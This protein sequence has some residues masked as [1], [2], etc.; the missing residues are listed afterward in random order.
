[1]LLGHLPGIELPHDFFPQPG[2]LFWTPAD[3][4]WVGGL[5]D[6]LM[7]A[8]H[9]GVPVL[10]HR[11]RKFEP[12]AAMALMGRHAVRNVFLPP[13]ALKMMRQVGVRGDG[14]ALRTL[15]S[16][17]ETLGAELLDWGR[18]VF[19]VTI[20]EFYGQT[21]CNLVVCNSATLFEVRPGSMGR[22]I[23]GHRVAVID[24]QGNV[25]PPGVEGSIVVARPDPVMFL[26][27]WNN[28]E[29]TRNKF[30]G[31]WLLTGD[32]GRMDEDGYLARRSDD[33]VSR[34][35]VTIGP[36]EI[37]ECLVRHPA[38]AM[39]AAI[40]IPDPIRPR[41]SSVRCCATA[42][43]RPNC[44]ARSRTTF[45]RSSPRTSIPARWSSCRS[46]RSPPPARS[47]AASCGNRQRR[48]LRHRNA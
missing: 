8:W 25:L 28:P 23:P 41:S 14:V 39:A 3:W 34:A 11:M 13:T 48:K 12:E 35:P 32:L 42:S 40:G 26:G 36:G 45:A 21:E 47:C 5:F 4:A 15:G 20:N 24:P 1:M 19:G 46:S 44:S 2:D 18:A 27:Y 37:E 17:G 22:A 38:V 10:A 30:V 9:Y 6:V 33:D 43:P 31:D 16:G 7:A 29:A